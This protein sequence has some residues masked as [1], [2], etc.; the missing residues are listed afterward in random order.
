M[1]REL[2]AKDTA[3]QHAQ[4][5]D[6]Q[7]FIDAIRHNNAVIEFAPDGT[8]IDA[9][10]TFLQLVGYRLEEIQGH[11]HA[12][13]CPPDYAA[14]EAYRQFWQ[15]LREGR[16]Q[17]G[18]FARLGQGGRQVWLQANYFP[19]IRDGVTVRVVKLASDVTAQANQRRETQA[20]IEALDRSQAVIEFTP[21]GEILHANDNFLQAMGYQLEQIVG[22]HHRL[23][24]DPDFYS[25]NPDFWSELAA[26]RFRSG[27]FHRLRRDGSDIWLEATYNPVFDASGRV[28][29]V[30]KFASDISQQINQTNS[31]RDITGAVHD[32]VHTTLRHADDGTSVLSDAVAA[33]ERISGA[34]G[35]SAGYAEQLMTQSGRISD[36]VGTI[37]SI[38]EQTNLL[39]LNAAIE[40]ARAGEQG[41]GFAVVADEVRQLANRAQHSTVEIR[42][43]VET[44][45]TLANRMSEQMQAASHC[46]GEGADLV[47]QAASVFAAVRADA[48]SLTDLIEPRS[49]A[50]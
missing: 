29:K 47:Q 14:S 13:F 16:A 49:N 5:A 6:Q 22:Q 42:E 21:E 46:A 20:V 36:I 19:I 27:Q 34:V 31:L 40:A 18:E 30:I 41:R 3:R 43:L 17:S 37:S 15:Q 39:A 44:N 2:F 33:A 38:A 45:R 32:A 24:C 10:D 8:I 9:N 1:F 12:L 7:A 26:G 4:S 25:K 48:T 50:A 23:F 28:V 35:N 11:H